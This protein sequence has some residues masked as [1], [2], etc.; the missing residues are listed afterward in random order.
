M[1]TTL[2]YDLVV[3][4]KSGKRSAENELFKRYLPFVYKHYAKFRRTIKF[5]T[6]PLEKEEFVSE[7]Y[8]EF[9][10]ALNYVNLTK[11]YDKDNWKFL[12]VYGFYL[13]SL[14]NRL[15]H[16][17]LQ[18]G[19]IESYIL[20]STNQEE[21]PILEIAD[22]IADAGTHCQ[23]TQEAEIV[24]KESYKTFQASLTPDERHV[25]NKRQVTSTDGKPKAISTIASECGVPFSRIQHINK[26]VENKFQDA[27]AQGYTK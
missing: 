3:Q 15:I 16:T 27:F 10:E 24:S 11:I 14:R 21:N 4:A 17:A 19:R 25:F 22:T 7:A 23:S 9:R 5:N 13:S 12:G 18:Q 8:I 6:D 20:D 2:D 26:S 1:T